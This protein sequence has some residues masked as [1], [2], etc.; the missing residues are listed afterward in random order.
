VSISYLSSSPQIKQTTDASFVAG[1]TIP[2][3]AIFITK[4]KQVIPQHHTMTTSA[5]TIVIATITDDVEQ[6]VR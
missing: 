4:N 1:K 5:A 3:A 6:Q 2:A